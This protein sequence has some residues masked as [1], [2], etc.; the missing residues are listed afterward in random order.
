MALL[1]RK[2]KSVL[3]KKLIASTLIET[4]T[5]MVIVTLVFGLGSG[6]YVNVMS[7]DN[8]IQKL[9]ARQ[10][11]NGISAESKK[12]KMYLDEKTSIEGFSIIKIVTPYN[13]SQE[14]SLLTLKAFDIK[15]KLIAQ[16][17]ELVLPE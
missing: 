13:N 9:K 17:K 6:T 1:N 16:R 4:V 3:G 12:K 5:A 7:A 8:H 2:I 11:L 10:I 14:L 15:Q